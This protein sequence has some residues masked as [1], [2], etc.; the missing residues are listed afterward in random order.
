MSLLGLVVLLVICGVGLWAINSFIPMA[1]GVKKLLNVVVVIA[2]VLFCLSFFGVFG[3]LGQFGNNHG[4]YLHGSRG[5][6]W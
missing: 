5:C 1:S 2:L 6:G 3:Y 4:H